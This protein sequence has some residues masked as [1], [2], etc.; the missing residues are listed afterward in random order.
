MSACA[1]STSC[2]P[3]YTRAR[4]GTA[5]TCARPCWTP[6]PARGRRPRAGPPRSCAGRRSRGFEQNAR[7]DLP[8][9]DWLVADFLWRELRAVLEI[10]SDEHHWNDSAQ[11]DATTR[12]QSRLATAGYTTMSR[13]PAL[14]RREPDQFGRDVAA[15]LRA[16]AR[17]P[18]A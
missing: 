1:P 15:W 5:P 2:G 10:D 12:R 8:D 4:G 14:V 13:R 16:R 7:I 9:G 6:E 17:E 3:S 11:R 18:A